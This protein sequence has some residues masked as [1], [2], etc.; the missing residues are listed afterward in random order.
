MPNIILS[1]LKVLP[2]LIE[3]KVCVIE[4][5][6]SGIYPPEYKLYKPAKTIQIT[7]GFDPLYYAILVSD[8]YPKCI[9]YS[10]EKERTAFLCNREISNHLKTVYKP[11]DYIHLHTRRGMYQIVEIHK[12]SVTLTCKKWEKL[13][14]GYV[15]LPIGYIKCLA[16]GNWN[17]SFT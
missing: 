7:D 6:A 13:K 2:K 9:V 5:E 8:K 16:G 12:N 10:T 3:G 11:G 14:Q 17:K 1:S 15:V 4:N